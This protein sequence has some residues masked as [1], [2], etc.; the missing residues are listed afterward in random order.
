MSIS[1]ER[2][3]RPARGM[4]LPLVV[5]IGGVLLVLGIT[6]H[7]FVG[8][9]NANVHLLAFSEVAHFLA[10]AGISSCIRSVREALQASGI[11][12][13]GNQALF[14]LLTK[15]EPLPDTSLMPLL[16]D[17]WNEDL[18]KFSKDLDKTANIKVE[19]WLRN[20]K[21]TET[22]P[23]A[24]VDPTAKTGW[25]SIESTGGYRGMK[26][27]LI[28]KRKIWVGNVL[29]PV[30]SKFTLHV[31]EA[32]K[33][34]EG[35]YN[36]IRNDYDS[37]ITDGPRP[38]VCFN[39]STPDAFH[40]F[41]GTP[42]SKILSDEKDPFVYLQRGWIWLGGCKIRLNITSGA[43][44]LGE[45]FH[46][47]DISNANSFQAIKFKTPAEKLPAPFQNPI[48]LPWDLIDASSPDPS[49]QPSYQ[50]GHSFV[51]EGFHDKSNRRQQNAMYER[52]VLSTTYEKPKYG[53][54]SSMLHLYGL[55]QK[56]FQ[57]R[58]K[59][60]GNV[61]AAFPRYACLDV[62]PM[63][64]DV[65]NM[66]ANTKPDPLYLLPSLP[67]Q[68]FRNNFP[69]TDFL[70]RHFGGPILATGF[71]FQDQA[72]YAKFMSCI[73]EIPYNTSYNSMQDIQTATGSRQFPPQSNV[74]S[75]DSGSDLILKRDKLTIYKGPVEAPR[76]LEVVKSRIQKD[77]PTVGEFWGTYYDKEKQVLRL[78]QI[79]RILNAD[80]ETFFLPPQQIAY[81]LKVEEGGMIILENGNLTCRGAVLLST[82]ECLT[83]VVARG[84]SVNFETPQMNQ[85]NILAP[86][87]ELGY[88]SRA[89]L[90][91][92]LCLRS[93][94]PDERTSGGNIRFREDQD[95][96]K[97]DYLKFY[98]IRIDD[99]DTFWH[100]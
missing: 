7:Q 37:N 8:Q 33:A 83:I 51:I 97:P 85:V 65:A 62:K 99:H 27:V 98:K 90:Y 69:I 36:I 87:A 14:K 34:D 86:Q 21:Q 28:I 91:G 44:A 1:Q 45:I 66:F 71:L 26:R 56:G 57:S 19:V 74:L 81:P 39:H 16:K 72:E 9:Q 22:D 40:P 89:E 4:I 79:V 35:A 70:N 32:R 63:E 77:I 67:P 75:E 92:T 5:I 42:I 18:K 53:S 73:V 50:F 48:N 2:Q 38:I 47:Y 95:P 61:T 30:V 12:G 80:K 13:Q 3:K 29:P 24:W 82:D 10:E 68:T 59:V 76:M 15:P 58:T 78:G 49:R 55:A 64:P 17:T 88:G 43:G 96:T 23:S 100:E 60:F 20:F 93:L 84:S 41:P 11:L 94:T 25:L 54:K 6:L 46:F 52:N 31:R